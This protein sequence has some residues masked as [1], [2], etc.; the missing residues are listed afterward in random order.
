[1]YVACIIVC[2]HILFSDICSLVI[3]CYYGSSSVQHS[4]YSGTDA[5]HINCASH[6]IGS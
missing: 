5:L 3:K 6:Y 2:I 4:L 1:M